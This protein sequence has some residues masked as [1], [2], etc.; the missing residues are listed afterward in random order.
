VSRTHAIIARHG[1]HARLLDN[2]SANGTFL[3]GRQIV[4]AKLNDGDVIRIGPV[5]MQYQEIR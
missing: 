2:R 1:L 5:V 4:A 3:N